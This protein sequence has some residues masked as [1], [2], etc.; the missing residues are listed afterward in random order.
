MSARSSHRRHPASLIPIAAHNPYLVNLM[1]SRVSLDMIDYVARQATK[2]IRLD[3]DSPCE[4]NFADIVQN[5]F[6]PSDLAAF[7]SKF[8][9]AY[10]Q[11]SSCASLDTIVFPHLSRAT[12]KQTACALRRYVLALIAFS[13][14][15]LSLIYSNRSAL[16]NPSH[17]PC[18]AYCNGQVSQR[19]VS[20]E[21]SLGQVFGPFQRHRDQL[22]GDSAIVFAGLRPAV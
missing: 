14:V 16:H 17:L 18:H 4:W 8:H 6:R 12:S 15:S 13:P 5:V 1:A 10:S 9:L 21:H 2:V 3:C 7:T 20:E 11:G 22:D 19:F